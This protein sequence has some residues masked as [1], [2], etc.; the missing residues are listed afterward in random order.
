M[1]TRIHRAPTQ[2]HSTVNAA[3]WQLTVLSSIVW[4]VLTAEIARGQ[5]SSVRT[6][7]DI[8]YSADRADT[9]YQK[10]RCKLDLYLPRKDGTSGFATIIWLHGGALRGGDK[11]G[12]MAVGIAKRFARDG[13]AVA[14]V[15]Y[16]LHPKVTFG[17]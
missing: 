10:D 16:R 5:K 14:A 12:K 8:P 17:A 13:I 6:V 3:R 2:F 7:R 15:N 4:V 11:V 1:Q 9:A